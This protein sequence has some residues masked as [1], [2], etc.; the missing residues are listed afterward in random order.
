M[1]Y[2]LL[3][4]F[5][6]GFASN[7]SFSQERYFHELR[8]FEDSTGTTQLFYRLY[9]SSSFTCTNEN[10]SW[11]LNTD[12]NNIRHL[13]P[14]SN[15]DSVKFYDGSTYSCVSYPSYKSSRIN[16][17]QFIR[18]D[19]SKW[20]VS[21]TSVLTDPDSGIETYKFTENHNYISTG[22]FGTN[23]LLTSADSL[24]FGTDSESKLTFKVPIDS[25]EW[26]DDHMFGLQTYYPDQGLSDSLY[27][28]NY[29]LAI[30]PQ[31]NQLYY[32]VGDS[33]SLIVSTNFSAN[34]SAVNSLI[35]L[36]NT[37]SLFFGTDSS[38]VYL[39]QDRELSYSNELG[40]D[41]SWTTID[42]SFIPNNKYSYFFDSDDQNPNLIYIADSSSVFKSSDYGSTFEKILDFK[43]QITGLY[44]KPNSEILYVLTKTDLYKVEN[45]QPTSIK[46]VPVSNEENPEIPTSV[47]LK[48]NYPNP[49]NPT[50]TIRFE[51]D[52]AT[53]AKLAV[54][55]LLGR[56]VRELVNEI[57]PAGINTIQFDATNLASGV[58][59]Y[60]LEA[61][62]VVQTKRLTLIK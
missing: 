2:L 23:H 32:A 59:L 7:N 31:N 21:Y 3:V 43:S 22:F 47:S 49:F 51:L 5:L 14:I 58:Y 50:T 42:L 55:D 52:Q 27:F 36:N 13:N 6:I 24:Y 46:Q 26:T 48:Q 62:G 8:G 53:F 16:D 37:A 15:T 10:G 60:R 28:D 12:S 56:K 25:D 61:N 35:K 11:D 18:N 45:G 1:K 4:T 19:I 29:L 33:S 17:F 57:R 34:F 44:K 30:H 41:G 20:I 40:K 39:F 38:S 54:Y 9:E